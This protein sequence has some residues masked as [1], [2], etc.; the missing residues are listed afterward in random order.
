MQHSWQNQKTA[1]ILDPKN[2]NEVKVHPKRQEA[3]RRCVAISDDINEQAINLT[4]WDQEYDQYSAGQFYGRIDECHLGGIQI[5]N[6]FTNQAL[7]QQCR[8]WPDS[9]WVGIPLSREV[10]RI[11]GQAVGADDV[12]WRHGGTTFELGSPADCNI[13]SIVVHKD[14]LLRL[15]ERNGNDLNLNRDHPRLKAGQQQVNNLSLLI[16]R[17]LES[18]TTRLNSDIHQDMLTQYIFDLLDSSDIDTQVPP[19]YK[20]R[21]A[22]VDRVREHVEHIG[23]LPVTM[24]ALCELACVSRRTLQYSFESILGISPVQFLRATRLN[25]VRRRLL[26]GDP[27]SIAD[28]AAN[29]GFHH[30]SQFAADYKRLFGERPSETLKRYPH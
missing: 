3:P 11:D 17:I 1:S 5:V 14:E 15:T 22:V 7:H 13:L 16:N 30:L 10:C 27:V 26:S 19:S 8:V 23:E 4:D 21:K 18:A 24:T 25:Q 6:E 29:Q 28:A 2:N 9:F 20:H 12:M